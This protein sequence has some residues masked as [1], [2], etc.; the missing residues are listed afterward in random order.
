VTR[1]PQADEVDVAT[2]QEV[3]KDG[4]M[5]S[6]HVRRADACRPEGTDSEEACRPDCSGASREARKAVGDT[7]DL[8]A[9][10][11]FETLESEFC[12]GACRA[13]DEIMD[14]ACLGQCIRCRDCPASGAWKS[15]GAMMMSRGED[16]HCNVDE[17]GHRPRRRVQATMPARS[18]EATLAGSSKWHEHLRH[19]FAR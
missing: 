6:R 18:A 9:V 7:S 2:P 4:P 1:K 10:S 14:L 5:L 15:E 19:S 16:R 8:M 11:L 17:D 12:D 3:P 13:C